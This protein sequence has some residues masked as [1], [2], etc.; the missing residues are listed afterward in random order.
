MGLGMSE[1]AEQ[2]ALFRWAA[3]ASGVHPELRLMFHVPNGGARSKATAGRLKAE[4]VRAGVP[5]ICLPVPR[6]GL[7][8]LY[9]ELKRSATPGKPRG[10]VSESQRDWLGALQAAGNCVAVAY[11]WEQA[12]GVIERY[13]G[14]VY[15]VADERV[16]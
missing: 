10:R 7:G 4:G 6:N 2:A 1:H 13:L 9:I 14:I 15:R 12:R 3:L 11:G 8:A 16:G 5:D